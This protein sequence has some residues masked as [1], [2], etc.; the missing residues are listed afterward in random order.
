ML[1][2]FKLRLH[3]PEGIFIARVRSQQQYGYLLAYRQEMGMSVAAAGFR[4]MTSALTA[5]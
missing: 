5:I 2:I 4:M 3:L 1:P